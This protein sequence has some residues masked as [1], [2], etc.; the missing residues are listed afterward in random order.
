MASAPGTA[1][2]GNLPDTARLS[3]TAGLMWPPEICPNAYTTPTM[4]SMKANEI[5]PSCAIENGTLVP[6]EITP[7]AA[8]DPAPTKTRHA[9]PI[10][11]AQSFCRVVGAAA[12]RFARRLGP[13]QVQA[14]GFSPP[15]GATRSL[16]AVRH[17]GTVFQG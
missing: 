7:V 4:T 17:Y 2:H 15:S 13:H 1:R 11:S 12:M 3:V 10:S 9:V 16:N 8:A 14:A 6:A 5:I